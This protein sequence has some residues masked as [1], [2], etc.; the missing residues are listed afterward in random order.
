ML[1]AAR[2]LSCT[3]FRPSETTIKRKNMFNEVRPK[4]SVFIPTYNYGQFI[5]K[6]LAS[7]A[8]Q[9]FQDYEVLI[10]DNASEDDTTNIVKRWTESDTR[11]RYYRNATN[12]GL[13]ASANIGFDAARGTYLVMLSADDYWED[14]FLAKSVAALD[15]NP[16]CSFSY[17]A[18]RNFNT[19]PGSEETNTV[20][21][22]APPKASGIYNE[23]APLLAHNWITNSIALIR[24]DLCSKIG[25]YVHPRL[26]HL[27]DWFLWLRLLTQGPAY[28]INESLGNYR[29]HSSSESARLINSNLSGFDHI[30]CFDLLTTEDYW[31]MPIKLLAKANQIRWLTGRPLCAIV[32][33]L[34]GNEAPPLIQAFFAHYQ[35]E[36]FTEAAHCILDQPVLKTDSDENAL[37]LL[38]RALQINPNLESARKLALRFLPSR[39]IS[40]LTG[41]HLAP[42][43]DSVNPLSKGIEYFEKADY[44]TS[45]EWLSKA[46]EAT[47]EDP[48]PAVYI[49]LI[50]ATQGLEENADAL[51]SHALILTPNR[52]DFLAALGET[53]LKAGNSRAALRYLQQAVRNQPDLFLA[54]PAMAEALRLEGAPDAAIQLLSS[55]VHIESDSQENILSVLIEL[56]TRRG[57]IAGL[58][59]TCIRLR[60][61]PAYHSLALRLLS[62]AGGNAER[63]LEEASWHFQKF[64]ASPPPSL[65]TI[66]RPDKPTITLAFMVSDFRREEQSGRLESLLMHLS[67]QRFRTL[68][69]DNDAMA[70]E[71]E[72]AQRCSLI[73]DQWL[74]IS[75]KDDHIVEADLAQRDP[76]ILI[77]LDGHGPKQRLSLIQA[78][79]IPLK[80]SWSDI[81]IGDASGIHQ[82]IG[83]ALLPSNSTIDSSRQ[84][85]LPGLGETFSLPE[86][87]CTSDDKAQA[88]SFGCLTAAIH[89]DAK[90]WQVFAALLS[91]ISGSRLRINLAELG[92]PAEAFISGIFATAGV[93][94]TRLEF[95]HATTREDVCHY[96]RDIKVGLA[97]IHSSGDQA[98]PACLWMETPFVAIRGQAPWASRPSALL[99][100]VGCQT[101]I[102]ENLDGYLAT[103]KSLFLAS[104]PQGLRQRL[105]NAGLTDAAGFTHLFETALSHA[106]SEGRP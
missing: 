104:P 89:I 96:W 29:L 10:I 12:L 26:Y 14:S 44:E 20:G 103:A 97:P 16:E 76:D 85:T 48:M 92:S 51:I 83:Q 36:L 13:F 50:S 53:F 82:L 65:P 99:D 39:E 71:S 101:W 68:V 21:Y 4:V 60:N 17:S 79:S 62:R 100:A 11:F 1:G 41:Q 49:A 63:I 40:Q 3:A 88:T 84:I 59:E 54:Y 47:P 70:S 7:V 81:P 72:T 5:G 66:S 42:Q 45:L 34:G 78:A 95:I 52:N 46:L 57:D 75:G 25:G 6:A 38:R 33:E 93:D 37:N 73:S 77:D 106:L 94:S 64:L 56:L 61:R 58:A 24:K 90:T 87:A 8:A 35:A 74:S 27:G 28:Y 98:L 91:E 9:T 80:A 22:I 2:G 43:L 31:T 18:W 30:V 23:T 19:L 105:K 55:A 32:L 67:S 15:A 102:A 86:L 69:I